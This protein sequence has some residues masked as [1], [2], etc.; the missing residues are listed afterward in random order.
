MGCL[1]LNILSGYQGRGQIAYAAELLAGQKSG[2][3][4]SKGVATMTLTAMGGTG[5]TEMNAVYKLQ[6]YSDKEWVN[7]KSWS[8]TK[9]GLLFKKTKEYSLTKTGKYRVKFTVTYYKGS[10]TEKKTV[11]STTAT[12]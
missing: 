2:L 4:I 11:Y 3:S 9:K 5:V 10:Q 12:Y 8:A 1:S 6:R 7:V